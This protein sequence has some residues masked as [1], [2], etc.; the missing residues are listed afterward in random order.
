VLLCIDGNLT[1][2][3]YLC[4]AACKVDVM[5]RCAMAFD[6]CKGGA[7]NGI[8]TGDDIDSGDCR[9]SD[10]QVAWESRLSEFTALSSVSHI[11]VTI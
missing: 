6:A 10:K 8:I 11:R 1:H 3:W 9:F 2:G 7:V 4:F 5:S